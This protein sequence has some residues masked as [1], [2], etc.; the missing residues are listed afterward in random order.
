[1]NYIEWVVS[2]AS[3]KDG[4]GKS[5]TFGWSAGLAEEKGVVGTREVAGVKGMVVGVVVVVV[6]VWLWLKGMVVV[7]VGVEVEL[8]W[9]REM[10]RA[11][12]EE[13][14]CLFLDGTTWRLAL[15]ETLPGSYS[16]L[17][18]NNALTFICFFTPLN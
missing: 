8:K 4:G 13:E 3:R 1:M 14:D 15:E 5:T 10:M 7:V 6:V 2:M 17:K 11:K 9:L 18:K 16:C 12:E